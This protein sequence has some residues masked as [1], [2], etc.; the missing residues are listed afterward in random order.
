M[1][2]RIDVF[3]STDKNGFILILEKDSK[4]KTTPFDTEVYRITEDSITYLSNSV[5]AKNE[6]IGDLILREDTPQKIQQNIEACLQ[7]FTV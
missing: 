1:N 5:I 7:R 4:S 2:P 6:L 3:E